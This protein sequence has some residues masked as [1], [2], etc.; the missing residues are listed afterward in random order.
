MLTLSRRIVSRARDL[1][2]ELDLPMARRSDIFEKDSLQ[3]F[4]ARTERV[5]DTARQRV[6]KEEAVPHEEVLLRV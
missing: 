1:L 3:A 2:C 4:I 6:L 5:M